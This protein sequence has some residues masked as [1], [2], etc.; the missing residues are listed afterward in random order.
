[1]DIY[2]IDDAWL[3]KFDL[4]GVESEDFQVSIHGHRV[5]VSGERRDWAVTQRCRAYQMEIAYNG[6]ER[7]IVLPV[8]LD[9]NSFGYEYRNGML[10]VTVVP[11]SCKGD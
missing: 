9:P 8:E 7:S 6:F 2:R 1:M 10:L 5:D 3:L 4:A 11:F